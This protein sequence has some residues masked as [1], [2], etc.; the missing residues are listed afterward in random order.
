MGMRLDFW[1][2]ILRPVEIAKS[3]GTLLRFSSWRRQAGR[4]TILSSVYC[5]NWYF[6]DRGIGSCKRPWVRSLL[7]IDCTRT[8][9]RTNNNEESG[10]PRWTPLCKEKDFLGIPCYGS[11]LTDEASLHL[12]L[13]RVNTNSCTNMAIWIGVGHDE[14]KSKYPE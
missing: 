10:S 5:T 4:I 14:E 11:L 2:F 9:A 12:P 1:K 13:L 7:I 6:P 3:G 8:T